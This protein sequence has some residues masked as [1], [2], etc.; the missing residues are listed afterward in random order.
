MQVIRD[1]KVEIVVFVIGVILQHASILV[2]NIKCVL[3]I[4]QNTKKL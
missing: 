4:V 1:G 3:D 2:R